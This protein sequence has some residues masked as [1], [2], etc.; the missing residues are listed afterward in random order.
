ML[1]KEN[2]LKATRTHLRENLVNVYRPNSSIRI[3]VDE[4]VPPNAGE[5]FIGIR[6]SLVQNLNPPSAVAK[7]IEYGLTISITRRVIGLANEHTGENILTDTQ[8]ERL[9]PSI[10]KRAREIAN[11]I[12]GSWTLMSSINES[13]PVGSGCFL[14]PLGLVS[15]DAEPQTVEEAH[16]DTEE[17]T[18]NPRYVGLLLELSFAGAEYHISR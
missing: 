12:D 6:C 9:K 18:G 13:L 7:V 11:L 15:E 10:E 1:E 17:E 5:E 2:L 3:M 8:F 16:F 14:S 4:R